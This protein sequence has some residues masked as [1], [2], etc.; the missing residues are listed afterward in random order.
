MN[1][2]YYYD[3]LLRYQKEQGKTMPYMNH[4][5]DHIF[6]HHKN[7]EERWFNIFDDGTVTFD[8]RYDNSYDRQRINIEYLPGDD[9]ELFNYD[10]IFKVGYIKF[11]GKCSKEDMLITLDKL[12]AHVA[13][14]MFE[15]ST[16]TLDS[17]PSVSAIYDDD[18][19][20]SN[21]FLLTTTGGVHMEIL[22]KNA[23]KKINKNRKFY[24][25]TPIPIDKDV[26]AS[27]CIYVYFIEDFTCGSNDYIYEMCN[28]GL[29]EMLGYM[30][31]VSDYKFKWVELDLPKPLY[32]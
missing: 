27:N 10:Q 30:K 25:L 31:G 17:S 7:I 20:L 6:I 19:K 8:S 1:A 21:G 22:P 28:V 5:F 2:K 18:C 23:I 4:S 9:Y 12:Y 14:L 26:K 32:L 13:L 15:K 16:K 29:E 11:K 3:L 24:D